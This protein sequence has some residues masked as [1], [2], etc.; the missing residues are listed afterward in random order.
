MSHELKTIIIA[1]IGECFN[2]DL[3]IAKRLMREA[4]DAGCDIVKFQTLDYE[5]ISKDDPENE[6][7]KKIALNPERINTLVGFARKVNIDILFT[8]ENVKTAKWI[9][10]AGFKSV[11]IA[12]STMADKKLIKFVNESFDYVFMSTGMASLD[13]VNEAVNNLKKVKGLYI[14]HCV[15]EYPTGPLLEQR[16]L[17]ALPHED[18]RL[19]MMKILMNLFPNHKIGFSDHTAGILAPIAA[20]ASGAKVIEK[21]ITLDRQ[22]P[23][24]NFETGGKYLGTDHILSIEPNELKEMVSQIR[25]VEKM[26]GEW[27]WERSKGEI[28]L[29]D[30]IRKR[31]SG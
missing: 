8:P 2:G 24:K 19:N 9:L 22:T 23:V 10:N 6:W 5:N 21:H 4:K 29:K 26:F 11:K 15:S 25:E 12:S 30:F 17:K 13:E 31:F 3:D 28:I 14:M 27:K 16:G 1:E 7:F 20:V 18:V